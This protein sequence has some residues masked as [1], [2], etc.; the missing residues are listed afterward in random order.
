MA[1]ATI[2]SRLDALEAKA[3]E[4]EALLEGLLALRDAKRTGDAERIV[5]VKAT[6]REMLDGGEVA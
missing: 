3:A 1:S 2:D 5:E 4:A 6:L